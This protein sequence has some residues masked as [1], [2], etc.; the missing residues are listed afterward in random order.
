MNF[1]RLLQDQGFKREVI[2]RGKKYV[3]NY[4]SNQGDASRK[5]IEFSVK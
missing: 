4:L 2:S 5:L 1:N 3:S